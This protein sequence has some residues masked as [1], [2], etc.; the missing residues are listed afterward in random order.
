MRLAFV[1]N[2][3]VGGGLSRFS[4]LLCKNLLQVAPTLQIDYFVHRINLLRTPEINSLTGKNV[5][6]K[7]LESSLLPATISE[8]IIKKIKSFNKAQ[9]GLMDQDLELEKR[10][11]G[12]D[13]A[14]FPSAHMMRKPNLSV[15]VTGT[16]HDFN[17]KYFF[18]QQ[19]FST[20]FVEEMDTAVIEWMNSG[21][22]ACSSYDVVTEAKKLYPGLSK[23]PEVVH[24]APVVFSSNLKEEEAQ[25]VLADLDI[26]YPYI[27]FPGNFYPHKNHLNLFA[28]FYL[29]KQRKQYENLKL[30]L[31]GMHTDQIKFGIA[32]RAG[33]QL[34]TKNSPNKHFDIRGLGYQSNHV[35][36]ALIKKAS[37][38]V[39]P[40]IYEA[41]CTPGM[42]AWHFG[43]P[44]AISDIPPFREHEQVWGVRSAY[45][46][47]MNPKNIADTIDEYLSNNAKAQE[48]GK[49][50]Q[51][52]I[53][54]YTWDI[55]AKG[56]LKIF[57]K[58]ANH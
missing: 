19:I 38:L 28:A 36:E 16:I 13:L 5:Q 30:I 35:I 52:N 1:D 25:K 27:I 24:L 58:A 57:E 56:Y 18:G 54:K 40:S 32:E 15:P 20:S 14:Y 9:S 41:I 21:L 10:I 26:D 37:L 17:W 3:P 48:D 31:T 33:V 53:S 43:T 22:T 42:D 6:V 8:R 49:I 51:E 50:S 2:L 4:Y 12:Y 47:P 46:D 45:F 44:T 55:T 29:L 34:L 23:Y 7:V 11:K 39:S